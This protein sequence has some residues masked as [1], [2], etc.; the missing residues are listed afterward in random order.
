MNRDRGS[1]HVSSN[2]WISHEQVYLQKM[3]YTMLF[4]LHLEVIR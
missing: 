4:A 1:G 2:R 3:C